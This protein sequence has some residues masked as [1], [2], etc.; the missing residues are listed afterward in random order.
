MKQALSQGALK[1]LLRTVLVLA[2]ARALVLRSAIWDCTG[3]HD[4]GSIVV[5]GV[6]VFCAYGSHSG[7]TDNDR[8]LM[9]DLREPDALSTYSAASGLCVTSKPL[10]ASQKQ[11]PFHANSQYT[12]VCVEHGLEADERFGSMCA[13]GTPDGHVSPPNSNDVFAC[14]PPSVL[15]LHPRTCKPAPTQTL[16]AYAYG[17]ALVQAPDSAEMYSQ[18]RVCTQYET[19]PACTCRTGYWRAGTECH[20]CPLGS[21][22]ADERVLRRVAAARLLLICSRLSKISTWCFTSA[23]FCDAQYAA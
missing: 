12:C 3:T 2:N 20:L 1:A 21:F 13:S 5:D 9:G 10:C 8:V 7:V 16:H 19:A 23:M 17:A 4:M 11:R 18:T 15:R 6:H 14:S 22:C